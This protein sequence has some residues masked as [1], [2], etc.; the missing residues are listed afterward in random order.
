[1]TWFLLLILPVSIR[2]DFNIIVWAT[3]MSYQTNVI[4]IGTNRVKKLPF[5]IVCYMSCSWAYLEKSIRLRCIKVYIDKFVI[6][7]RFI[8]IR[9]VKISL[10][11][12]HRVREW[13]FVCWHRHFLCSSWTLIRYRCSRRWKGSDE[14]FISVYKNVAKTTVILHCRSRTRCR[15]EILTSIFYLFDVFLSTIT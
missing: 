13:N 9:E 14:S 11:Q 12:R 8:E 15:S 6:I 7:I 5:V 4:G 1:M 3:I 10:R 2:C